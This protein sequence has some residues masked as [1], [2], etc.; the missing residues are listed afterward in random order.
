MKYIFSLLLSLFALCS[1]STAQ[2]FHLYL[3]GGVINYQGDLQAKRFTLNQS[4][5]FA[6]AGL[7]YEATDKL[8]FRLGF[9]IGKVSSD[10]KYSKLNQDRNLNFKAS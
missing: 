8:Y 3:T 4:H 1:F 10:D 5:P 9:M 7:Y 2:D 6:G